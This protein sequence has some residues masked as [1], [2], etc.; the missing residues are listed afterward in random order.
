[1]RYVLFATA[2][3]VD[4]GKTSLIKA[5]TGID[6]DR[7]PEEKQRGLSIDIGFAYLDFPEKGIRLEL[8]DVP[9]HERFIRNAIA[10]LSAVSGLILV[11]D[12]GEGVMPQ[13]LEHLRIAKGMGVRRGVGVLTKIDR[14]DPELVELAEE[15]L[16][17]L[18][19]G[20]GLGFPVVRV[21]S[22][23][24]EGL[25]EL[26][27]TLGDL[28]EEVEEAEEEPLRIVVDS[29]FTVRGYG[30]VLRGSCVSGSVRVGEEVTVEPLGRS[31]RVRALQNHG[32]FVERAVAGERVA[33]NL[34]E[35]D[36]NEVK[37][38]F[39]IVRKGGYVKSRILIVELEESVRPGGVY[40]IF[41]GMREEEGRFRTIEGRVYLLRLRGE[42]VSRRGDRLLVLNS[43]GRLLT[44]GRVLHPAVEISSK[45]F[46]RKHLGDLLDN[47]LIYLLRERGSRGMRREEVISRTGR[48]PELS[49]SEEVVVLKDKLYLKEH[50]L[51][52]ADRL[53]EKLKEAGEAVPKDRVLGELSIEEELLLYLLSL[54]R[55]WCV[56]EG[57]LLRDD[58]GTLPYEEDLR[59]LLSF[60]GRDF[61]REEE[62]LS[63]G[64]EREIL[65]FAVRKGY[66]HRI[67][68]DLLIS[69]DFLREL[70]AELRSLGE[71]FT[72]QEAKSRLGLTR[73]FLIP[74]L[75]H[76]D[77]LRL[78]VREGNLRRWTR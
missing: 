31:S 68:G 50:L 26:R 63:A 65:R 7:L 49:G 40:R 6:T 13:T 29:A 54:L 44:S 71:E 23:S 62:L 11:V 33:L 14:V 57:Y 69:D 19:K 21:S 67:G 66:V 32:L 22:V 24:G 53:G 76:L 4:H 46:V 12:A 35:I 18:L 45:G 70:V 16:K 77:R 37:R 72:L 1:M 27:A 5:L 8:I 48:F 17:E 75:E 52:L 25:E 43:S 20:E 56:R 3:H 34:P 10:G 36:R 60:M 39:W 38:G 74:L 30:T 78:T 47:F 59:R 41:F 58:G 51:L 42:V 64:F 55:G 9:G 61:R 2:G 15:E 28:L 73:K